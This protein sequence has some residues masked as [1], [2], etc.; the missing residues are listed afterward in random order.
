[1]IEFNKSAAALQKIY[2]FDSVTVFI[3]KN[4]RSWLK[5]YDWVG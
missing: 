5:Q 4:I 3:I 2:I 1:M